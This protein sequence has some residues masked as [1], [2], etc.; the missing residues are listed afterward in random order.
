MHTSWKQA[1]RLENASFELQMINGKNASF[2]VQMMNGRNA[3]FELKM[4]K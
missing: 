1:S 4:I 3:S 2:E